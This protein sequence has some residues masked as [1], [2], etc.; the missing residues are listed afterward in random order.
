VGQPNFENVHDS[1]SILVNLE[2]E[3]RSILKPLGIALAQFRIVLQQLVDYLG[4][5]DHITPV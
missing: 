2:L 1:G 4:V 3:V 5:E